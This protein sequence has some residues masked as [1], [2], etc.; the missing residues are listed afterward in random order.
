MFVQEV[1]RYYPFGPFPGAGIKE[2]FAWKSCEFKK[3]GLVL[4]DVYGTN[5]DPCLW[6]E[7]DWFIPERF[8]DWKGKLIRFNSTGR[9]R[10]GKRAQM[11]RGTD[12]TCGHGGKPFFSFR[13]G[14]FSTGTGF[15]DRPEKDA[16]AA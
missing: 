12:T 16:C 3:G 8:R 1:R 2:E 9:R 10:S 7:P 14:L 11:S 4:L 5:H 13:T 6:K 15:D